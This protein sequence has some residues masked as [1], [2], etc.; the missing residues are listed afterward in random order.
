MYVKCAEINCM[1]THISFYQKTISEEFLHKIK[2]T[3]FL[4][5]QLQRQFFAY[6]IKVEFCDQ[7][8]L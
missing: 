6:I 3:D 4:H 2:F 5:Y 7:F 8:I 1:N